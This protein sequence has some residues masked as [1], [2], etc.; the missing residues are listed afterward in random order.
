MNRLPKEKRL[1]VLSAL[2]EGNS[3]RSTERM[4]GVHR[5]TVIRLLLSV[6]DACGR[7]LND[8]IRNIRARRVQVDEI[9]TYVFKKQAHLDRYDD[10]HELKGDQ[11]VFVAMDADSKLAISHYVGKRDMTTAYCLMADLESRLA[12]RI[13]LTTDGFAPYL[14]AVEG[15]FGCEVDYGMLVKVYAENKS[16]SGGPAWYGPAH[17]LSAEPTPIMGGPDRRHISTSF[18]ERQNLTMRMQM[19][20]FT[21]LTNGFSKKLANLKAHVAL[22]FAW[23]NFA[24]VHSSLRVTPAME[25][26]LTDHPWTLGELLEAA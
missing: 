20:R 4:T 11:Y 14:Q 6:G 24:R 7:F 1:A 16:D 2:I 10:H 26:G 15:V 3:I 21:R 13:Q 5:D 9:W 8:H 22:H 12:H 23:Y 18:I 19:R 25:A 17:V